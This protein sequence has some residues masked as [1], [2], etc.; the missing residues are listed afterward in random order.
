MSLLANREMRSLEQL[1][2]TRPTYR[3]LIVIVFL[4]TGFLAGPATASGTDQLT[5]TGQEAATSK[6]RASASPSTIGLDDHAPRIDLNLEDRLGLSAKLTELMERA[7]EEA[8]S[9]TG[10]EVTWLDLPANTPND[11]RPGPEIRVILTRASPTDWGVK[12]TAMG[13]VVP[14]AAP[15]R[16]VVVFPLRVARVAGLEPDRE[17]GAQLGRDPRLARALGLVIVHEVVHAMAPSHPHAAHGIMRGR[18]NSVSL[19]TL[20]ARLDAACTVALVAAVR[21]AS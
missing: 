21:S 16:K 5:V 13:V 8:F 15:R 4:A 19:T 3:S 10:V 14:T 17:N 1:S 12:A 20:R 2:K 9:A 11:K 18:H 7:V 6:P